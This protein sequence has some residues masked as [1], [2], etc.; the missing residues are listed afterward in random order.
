MEKKILGNQAQ[1]TKVEKQANAEKKAKEPKAEKA[2]KPKV[3]KEDAAT[4]EG[5]EV[6]KL[7]K[8]MDDL[9]VQKIQLREKLT[10]RLATLT[11]RRAALV[12]R[13]SEIDAKLAKIPEETKL[14]PGK[15]KE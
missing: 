8:Q 9:D 15:K 11:L 7:V 12:K 2:T 6:T 10:K 1:E 3:E 5:A 4:G 14:S 13:R